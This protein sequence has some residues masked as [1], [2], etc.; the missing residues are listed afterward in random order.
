MIFFSGKT[1]HWNLSKKVFI[2]GSKFAFFAFYAKI[3]I[4]YRLYNFHL[5]FFKKKK[6]HRGGLWGATL[7][8]V[9]VLAS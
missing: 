6:R 7:E 5:V 1:K 8:F 3:T 4:F 2:R 9:R